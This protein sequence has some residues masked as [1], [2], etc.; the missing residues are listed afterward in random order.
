[1]SK[2]LELS[3]LKVASLTKLAFQ[4]GILQS[5]PKALLQQRLYEEITNV[6]A[7]NPEERYLSIDVGV[8]NL[9]F[10][11][12]SPGLHTIPSRGDI[13]TCYGRKTNAEIH[14]PPLL[15][16]LPVV[17]AWK[18]ME[19]DS[20]STSSIANAGPAGLSEV[21]LRVVKEQFLP[22]RPTH[23]LIERQRYRSG[24]NAAVTHWTTVVNS[25]EAMLHAIFRA[26]EAPT[27][28]SVD[29]KRVAQFWSPSV[30]MAETKKDE[31]LLNDGSKVAKTA[32]DIKTKHLKID[33]VGTWLE[34]RQSLALHNDDIRRT[35]NIFLKKWARERVSRT[36]QPKSSAD[37]ISSEGVKKLDDLADCLLQAVT[38]LKW[39]ENKRVLLKQIM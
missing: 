10:A 12:V 38:W 37:D 21:A 14:L 33:V 25:F 2:L 32:S 15:S 30:D 19:L 34:N 18:R 5:G 39:Q 11:L 20:G 9:A 26:L 35:A 36:K 3:S 7:F 28:Q 4:C 13:K 22:L 23:I 1:M 29:P 24:G 31:L 27:P 17:H 16:S 8:R 6:P